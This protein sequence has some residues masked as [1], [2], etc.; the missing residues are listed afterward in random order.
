MGIKCQLCSHSNSF[1]T[2]C[3]SVRPEAATLEFTRRTKVARRREWV[4]GGV[5]S[6]LLMSVI[7]ENRR[8]ICTLIS[9]LSLRD[10]TRRAEGSHKWKRQ[11]IN[12]HWHQHP[13]M[14]VLDVITVR[15]LFHWS[16]ASRSLFRHDN[17]LDFDLE[18]F[19]LVRWQMEKCLNELLCTTS[20]DCDC[21]CMSN[22]YFLSRQG[23]QWKATLNNF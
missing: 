4:V 21:Y 13:W 11:K 8:L 22:Y 17:L 1:K 12:S 10:A 23:S 7:T 16:H 20:S 5:N 18:W 19:L 15:T 6:R 9:S 2:I 3:P 14:A